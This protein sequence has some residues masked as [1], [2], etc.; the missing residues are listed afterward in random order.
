MKQSFVNLLLLGATLCPSLANAQFTPPKDECD[1]ANFAA[2]PVSGAPWTKGDGKGYFCDTK[3]K[4]GLV[5]C[6]VQT[7]AYKYHQKGFKVKYSD[8]TWGPLHGTTM[9]EYDKDNWTGDYSKNTIEWD[10]AAPLKDL[11]MIS[12]WPGFGKFSGEGIPDAVG[13]IRL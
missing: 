9:Q 4:T 2:S 1:N 12:N 7:W 6:G 13:G 11:R 10:C 3:W 5:I 8:G